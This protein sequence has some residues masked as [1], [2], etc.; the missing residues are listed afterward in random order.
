MKKK[1]KEG[2]KKNVSSFSRDATDSSPTDRPTDREG[3]GFQKSAQNQNQ[4]SKVSRYRKPSLFTTDI[5]LGEDSNLTCS[6]PPP[7]T[8]LNVHIQ[9]KQINF[10]FSLLFLF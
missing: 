1:Q 8:H 6:R 9:L 5:F 2:E 4:T 3:G 7:T 10:F